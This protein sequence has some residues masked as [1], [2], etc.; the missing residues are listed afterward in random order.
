MSCQ[1]CDSFTLVRLVFHEE[2]NRRTHELV[3]SRPVWIAEYAISELVDICLE[4]DPPPGPQA[5]RRLEQL[6]REPGLIPV[7]QDDSVLQWEDRLKVAVRQGEFRLDS[8]EALELATA[9]SLADRYVACA[10]SRVDFLSADDNLNSIA[11]NFPQLN[12]LNLTCV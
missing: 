11:D 8:I 12:V 10:G 1:F 9:L 4:L 3:G 5:L 6:K 7:K 2:C